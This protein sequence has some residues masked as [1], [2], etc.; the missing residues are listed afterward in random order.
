MAACGSFV[1]QVARA[2]ERISW[3]AR[4]LELGRAHV[5]QLFYALRT[6]IGGLGYY[7]RACLLILRGRFEYRT[8]RNAEIRFVSRRFYSSN[9]R[10]FEKPSFPELQS[11]RSK[12][13]RGVVETELFWEDDSIEKF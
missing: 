2:S 1:T 7:P 10:K 5:T 9:S 8:C 3:L 4:V 11:A 13:N 6:L 12:R